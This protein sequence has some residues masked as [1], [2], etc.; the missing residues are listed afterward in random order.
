M[1]APAGVASN[2][3]VLFQIA[4]ARL[5]GIVQEMQSSLFRSGYSTVIR[6]SQ[7]ASCAL[8]TPDGRVMA[9]HVVLPL[10]IGAFPACCAAVLKA[11]AGDIRLG[12]AYVLN[13]TY[14]GGSP[15]APDM[16]VL[17]P[18]FSGAALVG[19]SASMAHKS[20]IGGPVP[21]SCWSRAT[22]V[23]AEGLQL[24]ALRLERGGIAERDLERV[25]AA[26]SRSPHLVLGDLRAQVGAGR[27][28]E[29]RLLEVVRRYGAEMLSW[30]SSEVLVATRRRI[31]GALAL[32]PDGTAS[33]T[34]FIDDDGVDLG[35]PVKVAV[36][37]VKSGPDLEFDFS[38]SDPQ[39][40]G[41]ANIRPP[42]LRAA[43]A[44]VVM[45]LVGADTYVNSGLLDSFTVRSEEGSV[46]D[47]R[48]PAPVNTYN[49]TVHAV[50]DAAFDALTQIL[51]VGGMADGCASRSFVLKS[52]GD[53]PVQ[54]EILGGGAGALAGADGRSGTTVNHTNGRITP[55]EVVETEYPVRVL[56]T[57][58]VPDSGGGGRNRGGLAIR[59]SYRVLERSQLSL[60]STRHRI[61]PAGADGGDPGGRGRMTLVRAT[62]ETLELP[63]RCSGV[64]LDPGDGFVLDTPGGGG[65]GAARARDPLLVAAD[66][67]A[68]YVSVGAARRVYG[69]A[70]SVGAD[71]SAVVVAPETTRLRESEVVL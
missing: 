27:L 61:P 5:G 18:V 22:D 66:V 70:V 21:G 51:D 64:D 58:L 32:W 38:G 10:H 46:V 48:F 35:K 54:Y 62:G 30:Y 9:Q 16:A 2:D 52:S 60:R 59:R 1:T 20:D 71:G 33:A 13:H 28:G 42:L 50:V 56:E 41:P 36:R 63:A 34:R 43:C 15:H 69:V 57:S 11:Y 29:R 6:E 67:E 40:R 45:A 65:Y 17:V 47:S 3:A 55:V 7:D 39:T 53:H 68:G 44:Y 12:D 24:P 26:N 23:F 25:I 19:F 49:P 8:L 14:D 31:A 37:V 4:R